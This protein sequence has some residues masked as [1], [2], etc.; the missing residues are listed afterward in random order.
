MFPDIFLTSQIYRHVRWIF[1]FFF[2]EGG[3]EGCFLLL[4]LRFWLGFRLGFKLGLVLGIR[5]GLG[6]GFS[7]GLG[8]VFVLGLGL[9]FELGLALRLG[10]GLRVRIRVRVSVRVWARNF[11]G[12]SVRV[13]GC[14]GVCAGVW[15]RVRVFI[16]LFSI[17]ESYL[18]DPASNNML[19]QNIKSGTFFEFFF[20]F[21]NFELS[22]DTF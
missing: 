2:R 15:V 11:L 18:V 8:L 3:G 16:S 9:G 4:G 1:N 7:I 19:V 12:L 17:A 6:L 21:Q 22:P 10:L 5:L 14:G 20:N 13:M